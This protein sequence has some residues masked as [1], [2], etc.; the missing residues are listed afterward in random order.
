M[1]LRL[2]TN[3]F[4][5]ALFLSE[6]SEVKAGSAL[7]GGV[8]TVVFTLLYISYFRYVRLVFPL[9]KSISAFC[10]SSCLGLALTTKDVRIAFFSNNF[11]TMLMENTLSIGN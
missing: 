3:L 4:S 11:F 8:V 5:S 6:I 9:P 7:T 2:K 1:T 10:G